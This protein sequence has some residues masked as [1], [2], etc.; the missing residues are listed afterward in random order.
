MDKQDITKLLTLL[1]TIY[2]NRKPPKSSAV[3]EAWALVLS[4]WSYEDAKK[5]V[6]L[7]ARENMYYPNPSEL[8]PYLPKLPNPEQGTEALPEP[9]PA[10]LEKFYAWCEA[11]HKR[12]RAAGLM[13][14]SEAKRRGLTY[15]QWSALADAGGV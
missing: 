5:A 6:I 8:I 14:P 7:R 9:S 12:W 3:V 15:A 10:H 1:G 2:P 11:L 13:T 4:P